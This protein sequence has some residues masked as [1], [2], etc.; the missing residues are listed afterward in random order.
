MIAD[1]I[2][3]IK[4]ELPEDVT[5][6]AVSKFHTVP[7]IMEAYN[8]GQRQ[9]AESRQQEFSSKYPELPKDIEWH[10]IGPLQT[11]KVKVLVPHITLFHSVDRMKLAQCISKEA[12]SI[13]KV[14]DVLLQ[15]YI[16]DEDTKQGFGLDEIENI[17][18]GDELAKLEGVRVVGLMGMA[19]LTDDQDKIR[20]EFESLAKIFKK[21]DHLKILSMGMSHDYKIAVE[22][23]SNM[24]RIG[25][26][27]FGERE[28]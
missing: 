17:I 7:H 4:D 11:N 23:G 28:Y 12:H 14:V 3:K 6:V 27:I 16:A 24:V 19:T 15:V 10:F 18:E 5:L 22:C 9:F 2:K 21:Y 26:T 20:G 25:S 8:A 13:G 1:N